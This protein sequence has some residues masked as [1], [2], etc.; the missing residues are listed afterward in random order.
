M[1]DTLSNSQYGFRNNSTTCH[2]LID[3]HEQL[4][5]SVI[6]YVQLVFF[7]FKKDI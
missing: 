2:A 6:N 5:K 1:N 7:L 4:T 3:L